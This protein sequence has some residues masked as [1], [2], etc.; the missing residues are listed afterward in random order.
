LGNAYFYKGPL[1]VIWVVVRHAYGT[2]YWKKHERK[3][4]KWQSNLGLVHYNRRL[5]YY[6][7]STTHSELKEKRKA[8]LHVNLYV[9]LCSRYLE[10]VSHVV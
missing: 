9:K 6:P 10:A 5:V 4:I 1:R 8:A 7:M 3:C 2:A